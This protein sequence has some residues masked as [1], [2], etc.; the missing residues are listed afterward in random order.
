MAQH[1]NLKICNKSSNLRTIRQLPI[2][3]TKQ[4]LVQLLPQVLLL[5]QLQLVHNMP[6]NSIILIK[7]NSNNKL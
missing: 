5:K 3:L 4:K 7:K 1:C 2:S 6:S